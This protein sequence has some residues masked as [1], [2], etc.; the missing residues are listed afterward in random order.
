MWSPSAAQLPALLVKLQ[1]L[2]PAAGS[3]VAVLGSP[4]TLA[5]AAATEAWIDSQLH[6]QAAAQLQ[7][8]RHDDQRAPLAN[9]LLALTWHA[10][11][12][13]AAATTGNAAAAA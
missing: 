13:A 4:A 12:A 11:E 9:G 3:L 10:Q 1:R 7:P 6:A 2:R 5:E 8:M